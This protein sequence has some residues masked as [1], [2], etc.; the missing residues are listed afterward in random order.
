M[1][2]PALAAGAAAAGA[3]GSIPGCAHFVPIADDPDDQMVRPAQVD[4]NPTIADDLA[5]VI[6]SE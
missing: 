5:V 1:V 4:R 3:I 2:L 6:R